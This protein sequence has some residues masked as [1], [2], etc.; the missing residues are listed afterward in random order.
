MIHEP[1]LLT[2]RRRFER[3][4][5]EHVAAF[6]GALTGHVVDAMGGRGCLP[7]DIKPLFPDRAIML[8]VAVTCHTG[9]ADNLALFGAVDVAEPGDI[10]V[11]AT[12]RFMATSV[13]G[14]LL[15]GMARNKGVVGFVTDGM[16][17][18]IPGLREVGF[19]IFCAGV[20][21]NS[22]ARSG[23]GHVGTPVVI[24]DVAIDAGDLLVS[25]SDGVVV[26]PRERIE[27]TLERLVEIRAAE[28]A[29]EAEVRNG[30]TVPDF[31]KSILQS[32]SV[33]LD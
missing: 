30:L 8:G 31:I 25:D 16:V 15:L 20:T 29:F 18:D 5:A 4:A 27:M 17:R 2:L 10:L 6:Q 9:P 19:P 22:P 7:H 24:G 26:V 14:D 28:R 13:T 23:P 11:A 12:D 3:P 1:P 33:E 21:A 32:R